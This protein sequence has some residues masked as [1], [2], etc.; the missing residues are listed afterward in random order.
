MKAAFKAAAK[1]KPNNMVNKECIEDQTNMSAK[2]RSMKEFEK[3]LKE[4]YEDK[5]VS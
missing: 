4:Q 2:Y 1:E 5:G 3:E